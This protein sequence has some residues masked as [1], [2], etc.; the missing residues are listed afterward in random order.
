ME[1]SKA[2]TEK[3]SPDTLSH[4]NQNIILINKHNIGVF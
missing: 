3:R 2:C 4:P 1:R